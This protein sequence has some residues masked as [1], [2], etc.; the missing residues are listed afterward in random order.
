M[1]QVASKMSDASK[2]KIDLLLQKFVVVLNTIR[3]SHNRPIPM[4][5][6]ADAYSVLLKNK[7]LPQVKVKAKKSDE[8]SKK[9]RAIG[10]KAYIAQYFEEARRN[11]TS[12]I[13]CAKPGGE[14]IALAY[15]SRSAVHFELQ[16]HRDAISDI[17]HAFST[18]KYPVEKH[19]VLYERRAKSYLGL[20][21][22]T[23]ALADAKKVVSYV[24]NGNKDKEKVISNLTI[25]EDQEKV[26]SL[27]TDDE[28]NQEKVDRLKSLI[29]IIA[30]CVGKTDIPQLDPIEPKLSHERSENIKGAFCAMELATSPKM[31]RHMVATI[32]I[33]PGDILAVEKPVVS[34]LKPEFYDSFCDNCKMRCNSSIPCLTCN[35]V[36]FCSER[37]RLVSWESHHSIECDMLPTF[38]DL[39]LKLHAL[40]AVRAFLVA[41]KCGR[42]FEGQSDNQVYH[43]ISNLATHEQYRLRPKIIALASCVL[44]ILIRATKL[45]D[46]SV[47]LVGTSTRGQEPLLNLNHIL[48]GNF[49]AKCLKMV[50]YNA[51]DIGESS[52]MPSMDFDFTLVGG[53]LYSTLCL[54]NH[55]CDPNV[56]LYLFDERTRVIAAVKPIKK[57]DQIFVTYGPMFIH[58]TL[59]DR[60]KELKTKYLFDCKCDPCLY[61][62]PIWAEL[63]DTP[64]FV[65][66]AHPDVR[67][68]ITNSINEVHELWRV[69][70]NEPITEEQSTTML[71]YLSLYD[72][73]VE[74]PWKY[75]Y[76]AEEI[77][78]KQFSFKQKYVVGKQ[79]ERSM[80]PLRNIFIVFCL[81]VVV[82]IHLLILVDERTLT[83][84]SP[85]YL[86][87]FAPR[88]QSSI[89]V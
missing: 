54:I 74:R 39:G 50:P 71:Q 36:V 63:N 47:E 44:H 67:E 5:G 64:T 51:F 23:K 37:C 18:G 10:D 43:D 24:I 62:W 7:L 87:S 14:S 15:A 17:N 52:L 58:Q 38:I 40:N 55:S 66:D 12:A 6:C 61:D 60:Q 83:Q 9:L 76:V 86:L 56:F 48:A 77:I 20:S 84:L 3:K 45:F 59:D 31:G 1:L 72:K 79:Q 88:S 16:D 8:K 80:A 82:G 33:S 28:P 46:T 35:H 65:S 21:Q 75:H 25:V 34:V 26:I 4:L 68:D 69:V 89:L 32:D 73:G 13:C 29:Q 53:A 85:Q 41:T 49:I 70:E 2:S 11:Y 81:V 78:K 57:G 27:L 42:D 30:K 22:Y 19:H